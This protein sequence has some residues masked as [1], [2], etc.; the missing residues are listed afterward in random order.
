MNQDNRIK[1]EE[2]L[3]VN[4]ATL[5]LLS[6]RIEGDVKRGFFKSIGAPIGGAGI[7]AVFYVLFSWIPTQVEKMIENLPG[8]RQNIQVSVIDYLSDKDKGQA[9]IREQVDISSREFVQKAVTDRLADEKMTRHLND[10]I[11]KQTTAYYQSEEARK[12]VENIIQSHMGSH[13]VSRQIQNAVDKAL[14]PVLGNLSRDIDEKFGSVVYDIPEL[15]GTR[16]IRKESL[17]DLIHFLSSSQAAAIESD[18][19]PV[20][21]TIPIGRTRYMAEIIE[22]YIQ[23]LSARFG[24]HFNTIAIT[25]GD[26]RFLAL[27]PADRFMEVLKHNRGLMDLL[28]NVPG[29]PLADAF[30]IGAFGPS[31]ARRIRSDAVVREV[32]LTRSLWEAGT[33]F[34]FVGV[35]NNAGELIGITSRRKIIEGCLAAIQHS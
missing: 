10:L 35:I 16:Q 19:V 14:A 5:E 24:D 1:V 8:I 9:F 31:V 13:A 22:V 29:H 20:V 2:E 33:D 25:D 26:S 15:A 21:L 18:Q 28:N 23:E 32:L 4:E 12:L 7:I 34:K 17:G 30:I 11:D 3:Y 6:K 27:V